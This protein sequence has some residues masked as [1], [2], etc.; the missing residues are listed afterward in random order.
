[1]LYSDIDMYVVACN[2]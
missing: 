1:V 2:S